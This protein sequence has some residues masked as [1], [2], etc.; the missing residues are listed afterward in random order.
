L[1]GEVREPS[2][3]VTCIV[4]VADAM[5]VIETSEGKKGRM[6]GEGKIFKNVNIQGSEEEK[7]VV[8][9]GSQRREFLKSC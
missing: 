8:W 3:E 4:L 1:E 9:G 7:K 6:M 5:K 2:L